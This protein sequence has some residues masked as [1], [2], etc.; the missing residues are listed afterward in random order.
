ME[1]IEQD[2]FLGNLPYMTERGTFIINGAERVVVNQL[3]RSPGVFF[4]ETV[5]PNGL[6]T[7]QAQIIPLKGSWIEFTTD[8]TDMM[9][10]YIDRKRK[11]YVTTLLRAL[12]FSSDE[13]IL[14]LFDLVEEI[15]VNS[16]TRPDFSASISELYGSVS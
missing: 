1:T 11:F 2:V 7:Y 5:F 16:S 6:K 8:V 4:D 10:V 15:P 3:Q 12:G 13:E 14:K 9:Y